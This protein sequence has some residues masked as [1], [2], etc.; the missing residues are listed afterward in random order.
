MM[1]N[2]NDTRTRVPGWSWRS[3]AVAASAML[4]IACAGGP[5][6]SES[7]E[8]SLIRCGAV[9][10]QESVLSPDS[11]SG[12]LDYPHGDREKGRQ[13]ATT[14]KACILIEQLAAFRRI[15]GRSPSGLLE[16]PIDSSKGAKKDT[17]PARRLADGW[18]HPFRLVT[19]RDSVYLDSYGPDGAPGTADDVRYSE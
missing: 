5:R 1:L 16:L 9:G 6:S 2:S 11:L 4:S 14:R 3:S 17:M 13:A 8:P 18:D 19:I 7:I 15:A 10:I 12:G